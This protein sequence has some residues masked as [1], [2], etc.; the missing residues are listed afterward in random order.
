MY[1][2][3]GGKLTGITLIGNLEDETKTI[4]LTQKKVNSLIG[5][6]IS[7]EQI[8]D[9]LK[10]LNFSLAS[11][12][13]ALRA[14][15]VNPPYWRLDIDIEEDLIEE[16]ARMYGYEKIPAKAL[17]GEM[18]KKIDQSFFEL[19]YK[20]KTT[21]VNLGLTEV[22]TYSFY[23]TKIVS[24]FQFQVSSLIKIANPMSA[25]TAI[26]R[27]MLW[28]NL[29][30]VTAKNIRNG[31]KDAAIFE[32]GKV[33]LPRLESGKAGSPQK[34]DLTEE[35]YHLSIALCNGTDNPIQELNQIHQEALKHLTRGLTAQEGE[36]MPASQRPPCR[37][38]GGER[39]HLRGG[40]VGKE[41]FHPTR[42]TDYM[43][44]IHPRFVNKFGIEQRVAV[45]EIELTEQQ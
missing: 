32:I 15:E 7:P 28:P 43:A 25:E 3:L 8:E 4:E 26:L 42:Q 22:Q 35:S 20:L 36:E 13:D 12:G 11:Q 27:D 41:Y 34:G 30:E 6:T 38:A 10:K 37:E 31:A 40:Q 5:I 21:L 2:S 1:E 16:V 33:Y 23:S 24:S 39:L 45:L 17:V 18:P 44:E 29:L 19:I 14:W 9:S